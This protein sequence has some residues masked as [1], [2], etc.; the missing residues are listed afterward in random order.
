MNAN[1]GFQRD[2]ER[3][4]NGFLVQGNATLDTTADFVFNATWEWEVLN[5]SNKIQTQQGVL[6]Q[7]F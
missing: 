2:S 5:T 3:R 1:F 7:L 4:I 6:T